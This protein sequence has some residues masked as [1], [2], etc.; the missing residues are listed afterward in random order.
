MVIAAIIL[1]AVCLMSV[2]KKKADGWSAKP[3]S[4]PKPV[5]VVTPGGP[6]LWQ[7]FSSGVVSVA[8]LVAAAALL[9][10]WTATHHD[11]PVTN[12]YAPT[13]PASTTAPATPA[14]T[15]AEAAHASAT[16]GKR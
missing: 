8:F 2:L 1:V 5:Y 7:R 16:G 6:S 10:R 4:A 15:R 11:E 14:G 13:A 3:G 12:Y 9:L